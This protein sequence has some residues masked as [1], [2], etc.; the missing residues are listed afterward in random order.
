MADVSAMERRA[1]L[2]CSGSG[3]EC[4]YEWDRLKAEFRWRFY[5][6]G[7]FVASTVVSEKVSRIAERLVCRE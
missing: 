3:V 2:I 6:G 7:R 1:N 4:R 5:R